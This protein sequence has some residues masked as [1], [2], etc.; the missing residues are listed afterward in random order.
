MYHHLIQG[1][2]EKWQHLHWLHWWLRKCQ[3]SRQGPF[4]D[5]AKFSH[6]M[7]TSSS[8]NV[9]TLPSYLFFICWSPRQ[10]CANQAQ[11]QQAILAV[12]RCRALTWVLLL[13]WSSS[14]VKWRSPFWT[15]GRTSRRTWRGLT[16]TSPTC[17]SSWLAATQ[18]WRRYK[19]T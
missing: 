19:V 14:R 9:L 5:C 17:G 12:I 7:F 4:S 1:T 10:R 8:L 2:V 18:P 16:T 15:S 3:I 6:F 13:V 11:L